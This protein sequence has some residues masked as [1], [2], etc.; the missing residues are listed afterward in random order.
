MYCEAVELLTALGNMSQISG[1]VHAELAQTAAV[2]PEELYGCLV[3]IR[4]I[5]RLVS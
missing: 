4:N 2:L 5:R 3:A 1:V